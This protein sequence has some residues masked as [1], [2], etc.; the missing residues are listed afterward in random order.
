MILEYM[1]AGDWHE[2]ARALAAEGYRFIDLTVLDRSS[3]AWPGAEREPR[4]LVVV[5]L[6]NRIEGKRETVRIAAEGDPPTVPSVTDVWPGANF[7]ERE[8]FDLFGVTF[9]GHPNLKRIMLPDEW[10][11]HPLRKDY[12]VGKVTVEY[13]PQP[14]IQIDTPGQGTTRLDAAAEV[15]RLGQIAEDSAPTPEDVPSGREMT[16]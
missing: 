9:D 3:L 14:F 1:A 15:D 13:L 4:F 6:V 7:F 16:R 8:G 5:Q 10:E 12:G 2:R 11:G